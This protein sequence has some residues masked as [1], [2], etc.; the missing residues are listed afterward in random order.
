MT[1]STWS[2]AGNL[3]GA[4]V[5]PN[6]NVYVAD[7]A[8]GEIWK[9]T[10]S[11]NTMS[12]YMPNGS[13]ATGCFTT[14]GSG[15]PVSS[16]SNI[17]PRGISGDAYGNLYIGDFSGRAVYVV[18]NGDTSNKDLANLIV[19]ENP[20]KLTSVSQVVQGNL[21][22]L[23]GGGTTPAS[24]TACAAG[25]PLTAIDALGDGC[26]GTQISLGNP[27]QVAVD[28]YF[29]LYIT[30]GTNQRLRMI[31]A[32]PM[33]IY[34]QHYSAGTIAVIAGGGSNPAT[35]GAACGGSN[36]ATA[37]DLAGDG[38][39]GTQ[40]AMGTGT[41]NINGVAVDGAG[42]VYIA[43]ASGMQGKGDGTTTLIYTGAI[44]KLVPSVQPA[45]GAS[46]SYTINAAVG[47]LPGITTSTACSKE[48][49]SIGDSCPGTQAGLNGPTGLAIDVAGNLY[50]ADRSHSAVRRLDV[51]SRLVSLIG[52]APGTATNPAN[53]S[54][55]YTGGPTS[56]DAYGL[57]CP[58]TNVY[59]NHP[60]GSI[61]IAP[62]GSFWFVDQNN[63]LRQT[64]FPSIFPTTNVGSSA[65]VVSFYVADHGT[66]S[67]FSFSTQDFT[68]ASGYTCATTTG[69]LNNNVSLCTVNAVFAPLAPGLQFDALVMKDSNGITVLPPSVQGRG[70]GAGIAFDGAYRYL[71]GENLLAP[72]GVAVDGESNVFIADTANNQVIEIPAAG[73]QTTLVTQL[74]TP[75][76]VTISPM[77]DLYIS[78]T[79]SNRLLLL[80]AV[81]GTFSTTPAAVASGLAAPAGM[82]FDSGG[83]LYLADS[84]NHRVLKFPN[85]GSFPNTTI[86][87]AV[88]TGSI[89][90]QTPAAVAVNADNTIYIA[91]SGL[92]AVISVNSSGI[93]TLLS[94]VIGPTGL[95]LDAAGNLYISGTNGVSVIYAGTSNAVPLYDVN[96]SNPSG[97]AA[98][99]NG[100]LY[101]A[102]T[103]GSRVVGYQRASGLIPFGAIT[104]GSSSTP[105]NIT[106]TS[107]GNQA[108]QWT[109]ATQSDP[110]DFAISAAA[111]N[112]C[113]TGTLYA[114]GSTCGMQVTF[115]PSI[116]GALSTRWSQS[117][118]AVNAF[119]LGFT[120]SGTGVAVTTTSASAAISVD[121]VSSTYGQAVNAI[122]SVTA[123]SGS[124][125][126]TGTVT[127]VL[128]GVGCS[129]V[130]L[131][132]GAA[133]LSLGTLPAGTHTLTA[134]YSGDINFSG[135]DASAV[136]FT[137]LQ[138]APVITWAPAANSQTYGTVIGSG[139]LDATANVGG[140]M[141]YTAQAGGAP[142]AIDA[143]T[144]LPG[145][146]YTLTSVFTP[147]DSTDYTSVSSTQS[148]I[149]SGGTTTNIQWQPAQSAQVYGTSVGSDVLNATTQPAVA[150]AIGYT[151]KAGAG[152][153]QTVNAS[154]VLNAASYVLTAIFTPSNPGQYLPSTALQN[155]SVTPVPLGITVANASRSYGMADPVF[156]ATASGL[157]NGDSLGTTILVAMQSDAA[158]ASP[159]GT[160]AIH[161]TVGGAASTNYSASV[162]PGT[163]TISQAASTAVLTGSSQN[164][165]AG[166]TITLSATVSSTTSGVPSGSV[167][168][169]EDGG[170]LT[171]GALVNGT[172]TYTTGTIAAGNHTFT[173]LYGGDTNF[174]ASISA[175]LAVVASLA[176]D[177]TATAVPSSISITRGGNGSVVITI[178]PVGHY[179][180]SIT[181]SCGVLPN[182]VDC[183]FL[184]PVL[185]ADGSGAVVQSTLTVSTTASARMYPPAMRGSSTFV[186]AGCALLLC[187]I[188]RRSR[189]M[190]RM[191]AWILSS[192][193][194]AAGLMACGG[195]VSSNGPISAQPG[196]YTITI[197]ATGSAGSIVHQIVFPLIIQ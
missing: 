166:Q 130:T 45:S 155:Y 176:P 59:A 37:T 17:K 128:D 68:V 197:T 98:D 117:G 57:G 148:Y 46:L 109:A 169:Q 20:S 92:G 126:P 10:P 182:H 141:A 16:A 102:D 145:G 122:I 39:W 103:G 177:F 44:R 64:G 191:G 131:L 12:V 120:A 189:R 11:S 112:G 129:P 147:T 83:N 79:G 180:G 31:V 1:N 22:L 111:T 110:T 91:D 160:Y 47:F 26:L 196:S 152:A 28:R 27:Y 125:V 179:Q 80:S 30:D 135:A 134:S 87:S 172:A 65:T 113:A 168:F 76:A 115:S 35:I 14:H 127:P 75:S 99:R 114:P 119:T 146:S 90:L 159:P 171:S 34:G 192:A 86:G 81:T 140:T 162:T 15:C 142:F 139:V 97:I 60:Q 66:P 138:A 6:G 106:L 154:T 4:V 153:P 150:G 161:G 25:S 21:Y 116:A 165:T 178:T 104:V 149:V 32:N 48:V 74:N 70:T 7:Y 188:R 29:N 186:F 23:A 123:G 190:V 43:D 144:V 175:G 158:A 36:S 107:T 85:W 181:L 118:N 173:A 41:S 89:I 62:D 2:T 133:M 170:A 156:H 184:P 187:S 51:I 19:A 93:A 151:A 96:L 100:T 121:P 54:A 5:D 18:Y 33:T 72:K 174:I 105:G 88:A 24:G 73:S 78:D 194:G 67:A 193:M 167:T 8:N 163:L 183:T 195:G 124:S 58:V 53:G 84:G 69:G 38:C 77:G 101:I 9:Y 63:I 94:S 13:S 42:N 82:A 95:A 55:C 71:I 61:G 164:I 143:S 56:G 157:V 52:G 40:V 137:V 3:W 50:F 136:A 49:D 185:N 132:N 108:L